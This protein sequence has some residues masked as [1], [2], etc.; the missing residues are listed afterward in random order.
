MKVLVTGAHGFIGSHACE[1]LL[2]RGYQ[3]RALV[4]PWGE[5][6]NLAAVLAH[7]PFELTR[8]DIT[9]PASLKG[10]CNSCD[11]VLH[12]AARVADWG[13]W[14]QF[15]QVNVHGTK[16]LLREAEASGVERFVLVSS[17]AVHRYTG[18]RNAD[19]SEVPKNNTE[20]AYGR[21]KIL[22]EDAV[23]NAPVGGVVVRP[24]LWPFGPRDPNFLRV[25]Q[26]LKRG[27]LPFVGE[28][29]SVINTAYVGNLVRGL[30]LALKTDEAKLTCRTYV[31]ADEGMPTWL[32]LFGTLAELLDVPSPRLH[33]TPKLVVP[34]AKMTESV[35]AK[36][37][38]GLEPPL[39]S[40]RAKLMT[41][42]VHFSLQT[43]KDDL[44]Y[45]PELSWQAGLVETLQQLKIRK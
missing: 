24:G 45:A 8:A 27:L 19:P 25:V 35:Y 6:T 14:A 20:Q 41:N 43:A 28:G 12:A 18:F 34:L 29:T 31:I 2:A 10:V 44:G 22:A 30:E 11:A 16:N 36:V 17:V 23:L 7:P 32:E 37:A 1:H 3:V 5:V 42:D 4:S 33:L 39:T 13:Q 21:S 9:D 26:A 15:E 38:P 40:Y